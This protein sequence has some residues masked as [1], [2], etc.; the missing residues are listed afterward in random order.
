MREGTRVRVTIPE[1]TR[2][3]WSRYNHMEGERVDGGVELDTGAFIDC[4]EQWLETVDD[5]GEEEPGPVD[6]VDED[7][8]DA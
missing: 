5:A 1:G 4:P 8:E 3:R 7:G 2:N 6:P